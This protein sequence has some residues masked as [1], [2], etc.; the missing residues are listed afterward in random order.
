DDSV[1]P[2]RRLDLR[3]LKLTLED[4]AWPARGPARVA[5]AAELPEAGTLMVGGTAGLDTRAV[6]VTVEARDVALAPYRAFLPVNAPIAGRAGATLRVKGVLTDAPRV[7]V[8][9]TASAGRLTL[10]PGASPPV[11]VERIEVTALEAEWP[12]RV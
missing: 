1:S 11:A 6:D 8:S 3:A 4:V 10:G 5:L 12:T 9:G 7:T 2:P